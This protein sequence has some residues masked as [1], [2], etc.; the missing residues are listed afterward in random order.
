MTFKFINADTSCLRL[1][2]LRDMALSSNADKKTHPPY[3]CFSM[4]NTM[5]IY[6]YKNMSSL[7]VKALCGNGYRRRQTVCILSAINKTSLKITFGG[8]A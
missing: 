2:A 3:K 4:K 7:M 1:K 5:N 8:V 6:V